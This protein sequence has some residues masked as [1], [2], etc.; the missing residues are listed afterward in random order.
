MPAKTAASTIGV[1]VSGGLDSCIL[2][3][4][5][6]HSGRRVQPFFVRSQLVWEQAELAAVEEYLTAVAAPDLAEL[7]VL[8]LPVS[9]LYQGHWSLTGDEFPGASSPAEAVFLPG[10]NALLVIKAALWCH[11][12]G[13]R[14][15][16]LGVLASNPFADARCE[17]FGQLQ[18]ALNAGMG[19]RLRIVRPFARLDKRRVMQLG[20]GLPLEMT[21]S[22][23]APVG[24]LHCGRCNKCA[25]RQ[26]AFQLAGIEDPTRYALDPVP[27]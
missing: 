3:S 22:C 23:I 24:R 2:L 16:A 18:S 26:D 25:E 1:L 6:L 10:R 19:G 15:L 12:H 21:F 5:L 14:R 20:R 9:D 8:D 4:R 27:D 17:F 11:L 13:I 7:V